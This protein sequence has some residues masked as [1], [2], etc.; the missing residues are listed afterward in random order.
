MSCQGLL[1]PKVGCQ[2]HWRSGKL[3]CSISHMHPPSAAAV[4]ARG[5]CLALAPF[6]VRQARFTCR[7]SEQPRRQLLH[8]LRGSL[9]A[10][11]ACPDFV[12]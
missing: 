4:V 9:L 3:G 5:L 6:A 12:Q 10:L 1:L 2:G 7:G 11:I 8:K